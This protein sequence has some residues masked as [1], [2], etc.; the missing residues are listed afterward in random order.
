MADRVIVILCDEDTAW[1][2]LTEEHPEQF[3]R[4]IMVDP[5]HPHSVAHILES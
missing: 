3:K 2:I 4:V 5:D 1:R